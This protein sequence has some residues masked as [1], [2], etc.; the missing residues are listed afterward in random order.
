MIDIGLTRKI[1]G[2]GRVVIPKEL[3]ER[4]NIRENDYLEFSLLEDGLIIKKHS[5]L[6]RVKE[7]AQEL[8][9]ILNSFLDAEVFIAECDKV[10]AYSGKYKDKYIDKDISSTLSKSIRRRESLFEKYNKK[11]SII[12]NEIIDCSYINETI[13]VNYE[14][15]GLICLY[16]TDRS[17]DDNDL[18]IVK[19]VSSF[20]TKY[21]EE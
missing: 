12:N 13:V 19:I 8:T 17:V 3:R 9:D 6:G 1:D 5:K 20:F 16:R 11:F 10:L 14:D 7:I 2:M 4:F 18:K 21:L 15:V